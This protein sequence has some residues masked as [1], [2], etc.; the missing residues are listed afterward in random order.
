[1]KI[2]RNISAA[3]CALS[4]RV[5][6][7]RGAKGKYPFDNEN[8]YHTLVKISG[9][10]THNPVK[11]AKNFHAAYQHNLERI[12]YIE[13]MMSMLEEPSLMTKIFNRMF[14]K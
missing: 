14:K 2:L 8:Y 1:M 7:T 3:R 4:D 10:S 5:M 6:I 11:I 9:P 12:K 13:K